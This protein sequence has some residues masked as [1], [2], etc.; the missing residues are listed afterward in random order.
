LEIDV[1]AALREVALLLCRKRADTVADRGI[2]Q[3]DLLIV[4]AR[5]AAHDEAE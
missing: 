5:G 2:S 1:E 4:G 3:G